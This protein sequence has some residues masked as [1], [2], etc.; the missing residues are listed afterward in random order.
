MSRA[1]FVLVGGTSSRMGRDKAVLPYLNL[2]LA[3]RVARE[4]EAAAGNLA[5]VGNPGRYAGLGRRVIPDL[6]PGNGP[7]GGIEAALDDSEADWNLIVAC[8]MPGISAPFLRRLLD[9]A[10]EAGSDCLVPVSPSGHLEPLCAVYHRRC[11]AAVSRALDRGIKKVTEAY[12]DLHVT[13]WPAREERWFE[14]LNTT[15]QWSHHLAAGGKDN[16]NE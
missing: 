2:P 3:E 16:P 4:V 10:E 14:N 13:R 6:R 5:L 11:L 12:E 9:Q 8:D 1:G 7:L 15:E